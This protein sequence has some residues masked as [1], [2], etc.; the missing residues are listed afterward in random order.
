[1]TKRVVESLLQSAGRKIALQKGVPNPQEGKLRCRRTSKSAGR[2]ITLQKGVPNPQ[3]GK[4]CCRRT[5]Q[6]RRKENYVA[7]GLSKSAGR[8]FTLQK[9]C[10]KFTGRKFAARE[11]CR[12]FFENNWDVSFS[13]VVYTFGKGCAA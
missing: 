3:E 4:L 13:F 11:S 2:K 7:E 9:N 10:C 5:F 8:K 12:I 6:I 1:M